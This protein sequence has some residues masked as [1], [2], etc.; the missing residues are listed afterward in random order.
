MVE[1]TEARMGTGGA[2]PK[3]G[4]F[5]RDFLREVGE[6]YPSEI[7]QAY[8]STYRER[9]TLKGRTFRLCT[10][11]SF[12]TYISKLILTGLVERTGRTEVSDN[13][14][15]RAL[16][17]PERIYVRLTHKGEMAPSFVWLHPLR[18]YYYPQ[19]WERADYGEYVKR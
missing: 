6:S 10:Y 16:E 7:H 14:K 17:Y 5:I 15:A 19:D 3:V 18:I 12:M 2:S 4:V 13:P 1:D 8:K 11:N 9:R